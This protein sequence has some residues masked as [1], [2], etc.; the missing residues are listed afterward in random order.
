M[1]LDYNQ[2]INIVNKIFALFKLKEYFNKIAKV[3]G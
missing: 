1:L 2:P 3:N